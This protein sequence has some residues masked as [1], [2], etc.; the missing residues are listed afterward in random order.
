[1]ASG[2]KLYQKL[3]EDFPIEETETVK[4]YAIR[5]KSELI[6]RG[7]DSNRAI[8]GITDSIRPYLPQD[9]KVKVKRS[10]TLNG[11]GEIITE[12]YGYIKESIP[13][14]MDKFEVEKF[15]TD[16]NGGAGWF[17]FKQKDIDYI[18][19]I[20]AL[21]SQLKFDKAK[22]FKKQKS[23]RALKITLSDVHVGMSVKDSLF[24][25][26]YGK[27][28][29]QNSMD[30]VF[31]SVMSE[32]MANGRFDV[33]IIQD[34][35]DG[36]DGYNG[37]TTRGGHSLEQ[38]M[39]NNEA[40][41]T[42]IAGKLSLLKRIIESDIANSV[43]IYDTVN[44]NHSGDFGYSASYAT[45]LYIE[46]VYKNVKYT[47]FEKF[48]EHF[49]YGEHCFIQCHGKDKQYMKSGMPLKLDDKT[50]RFISQYIDKYKIQSR[51]IHFEKGD[52]HQIGFNKCK[53]FDYRNFMSF[54]PPSNWVQHNFGD[55]YSGYSIQVIESNT[56]EIKHIDY[57]LDYEV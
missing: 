37:Q 27:E 15:T 32:Y 9:R 29:Y 46:A 8:K 24:E 20:K 52:L 1:M 6:N 42:F 25:Y 22:P 49:F 10:E 12:R 19:E 56:R 33:V 13:V 14:E 51:Y 34:L 39:S 7:M 23:K 28:E 5:M 48:I 11:K 44:C 3:L 18:E 41:R 36:L 16:S 47:I 30:L 54:A 50:Q 43:E 35:G 57:F 2:E 31:D 26:K 55:G 40:Y 17:K 53:Q 4:D 38:S 21:F 45:K